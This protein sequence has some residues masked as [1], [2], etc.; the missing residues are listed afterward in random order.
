MISESDIGD[1][2]SEDPITRHF[3]NGFIRLH[4]L[5]QA[6]AQP[7]YGAEI[8]E[9]LVRHGYRMPSGTLY[10]TLH[11]LEH[12]GYLR[13][14]I[15]VVA[16]RQ[17]KYYRATSAGRRVLTQARRRLAGLVTHVLDGN[18]SLRTIR[19]RR[20]LPNNQAPAAANHRNPRRPRAGDRLASPKARS[21]RTE[22]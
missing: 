1:A 21:P 9:E 16:G 13:N 2:M 4:I 12:L 20:Q 5:H 14:R 11:L 22:R 8:A 17:R 7:V 18:R 10:P 15:E 3:F 19:Q 6:A